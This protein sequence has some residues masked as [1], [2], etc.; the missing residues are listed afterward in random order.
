MFLARAIDL[1]P[2]LTDASRFSRE[3]CNEKINTY[4]NF[5]DK[6]VSKTKRTATNR[7]GLFDVSNDLFLLR[8]PVRKVG[9]RRQNKCNGQH[10]AKRGKSIGFVL[11]YHADVNA[12]D[13]VVH[14]SYK[15]RNNRLYRKFEYQR[16]NFAFF[17][18]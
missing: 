4:T 3:F 17:Q 13:N 9:K 1:H 12:V 14:K 15:L 5:R 2:D 8:R 6:L 11:R 16:K 18:L 7:S 10:Y